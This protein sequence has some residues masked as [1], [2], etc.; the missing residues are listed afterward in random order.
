MAQ[1]AI[2]TNRPTSTPIAVIATSRRW[3]TFIQ[4]LFFVAGFGAFIVGFFGL[5]GTALGD[6]FFDVKDVLRVVGGIAVILFGLFTLR[7]INIPFLYSDTRKGLTSTGRKVGAAQS[8]ITGISFAA[9]WTP[10]IGPFLGAILSMSVTT[11]LGT[12]LALLVAY[13]LGLGVPFLLV[14]LLFDRMTPVLN[15][16]KRN[17]RIIEIVSGSL[18]ILVGI[19][20]LTGGVQRLSAQLGAFDLGLEAMVLGAGASAAPSIIIAAVAGFLSFASP[21]VLPLLPAYLGFIGGWAVNGAAGAAANTVASADI[22]VADAT[23]TSPSR[24]Y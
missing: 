14:A 17:M 2:P 16:L 1:Q 12:R 15:A 23:Q 6:V 21:C 22:A 19:A 11:E 4:G 8:F 24:G 18:L 10:C 20:L 7:I 9:G 3:A 5:V 13:T